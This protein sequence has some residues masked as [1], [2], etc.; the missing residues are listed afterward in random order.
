MENVALS[1]ATG[2][3]FRTIGRIDTAKNEAVPL[4]AR[5][6]RCSEYSEKQEYVAKP[7]ES[8]TLTDP[9]NRT[10][11]FNRYGAKN[12]SRKTTCHLPVGH[13][14]NDAGPQLLPVAG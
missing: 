1:T 6:S 12:S 14:A 5:S 4:S 11:R 9:G 13:G 2:N 7:S 8:G 3:M 10:P